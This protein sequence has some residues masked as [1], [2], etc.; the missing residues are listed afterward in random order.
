MKGRLEALATNVI[1]ALHSRN[2]TLATCE[3]LTGGKIGATLTSV[4]GSSQVFRGGLITYA[5]DLKVKLA[6]VDAAWVAEHG[7]INEQTAIQMA[8]GAKAACGS[9]IAVS[10]TGVAGPDGEDGVAPGVVWIGLALPD[11][12]TFATEYDFASAGGREEIRAA[13]VEVALTMVQ[14]NIE[15]FTCCFPK[16]NPRPRS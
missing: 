13:T 5:S 7:V 8:D 2:L 11:R 4:P 3:S 16:Y 10:V 9:D 6:A 15:Q 14:G 12:K 1:K